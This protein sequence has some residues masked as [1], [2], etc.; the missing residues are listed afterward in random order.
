[1]LLISVRLAA[2]ARRLGIKHLQANDWVMLTVIPWYTLLV[3]SCNQIIF[4]GGSNYMTPDEIAALTPEIREARISGSKW[5][6]LS[7]EVMVLTI[8]TCKVC[9]LLIYR[10]LTEGLRQATLINGVFIYVIL[11]FVATQIAFFTTCRPFSGYW[12][13]PAISDQCWSYY[14]FEI[15]EG[16]FNVSSD[17]FVLLIAIP[18]LIRVRLPVQ[19]KVALVTVFGM[20]GFVIAAAILTK[21]YSLVPY[22]VSYTYLNWYFREASVS[23]YVANLPAL[24]GIIRDTFPAVGYWGYPNTSYSGSTQVDSGRP[25][26]GGARSNG[27]VDGKDDLQMYHRMGSAVTNTERDEDAIEQYQSQEHIVPPQQSLRPSAS[28]GRLAINKDVEFTVSEDTDIEDRAAVMPHVQGY[29]AVS[30]YKS[31][32]TAGTSHK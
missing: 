20:G 11:G 30:N 28:S 16:V 32:I 1:M 24:W 23:V 19:Q 22:L 6:L 31:D 5:V 7:E 14:N 18:L 29:P 2:R 25:R 13:V 10:R 26:Y 9:M 21:V 8:W 15:V 12:S 27:T 3:V 17:C 4:G